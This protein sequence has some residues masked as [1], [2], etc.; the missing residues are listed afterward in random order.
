VAS[1]FDMISIVIVTYNSSAH[2]PRC[3]ES[4]QDSGAEI[5][6]VDNASADGT[7][8]LVRRLF[9]AVK[10][11]AAPRNLGFAAGANLGVRN[12]R[13]EALLFVNPDVVCQSPLAGLEEALESSPQAVA[14]APRLVDAEGRPQVGFNVRRLPTPAALLFEILALNRC[15]PNNPV[16]RNYRCLDF[17][18]RRPAEIEQPAAACLLVRRRSF[19]H[20][21]GF[22]ERFYPLWFEDV[23]LC[24]RLRRQG[25]KILYL[26]DFVFQHA[27]GHSL[28]SITFSERQVYWYRNLLYY[29]SKQFPWTIGVALRAALFCGVGLR[30]A[31]ELPGLFRGLQPGAHHRGERIG[32]YVKAAKLAFLGWR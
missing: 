31:A 13:G 5:V 1:K 11:I 18:Y 6:V 25:G 29:V 10:L 14:V 24:L 15:F 9:P 23:D 28:D 8:A 20:C 21:G 7:A 26:P 3:L 30:I 27:G 4:F 17:D 12:S 32:A 2:I 16:N 22:D 19:E